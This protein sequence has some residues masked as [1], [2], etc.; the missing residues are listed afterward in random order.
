MIIGARAHDYGRLP[1]KELFRRI[2][3]DGFKTIQLALKKAIDGISRQNDITDDLLKTVQGELLASGLSVGVLGVYVEPSLYEQALRQ[4]SVMEF[5]CGLKIAKALSAG[6]IGT[7]TTSLEKQPQVSRSV[8]LK[9]LYTSLEEILPQAECLGV[10]VGI[11]P[12]HYHTVNTPE[13]TRDVL[14]TMQSKRLK[15]IFDPVNLLSPEEV[16]TQHKLWDRAFECFGEDI[17]AVHIK[18]IALDQS[19]KL[20]SVDLQDSIVD[21][22]Y[23]FKYLRE[24]NKNLPVLREEVAPCNAL[25]DIEFIGK[26]IHEN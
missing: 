12:V 4:S 7:E 8:A 18:G 17:V 10:T 16:P 22:D 9:C 13:L 11:E 21:Y 20:V 6:C 1:S 15:V 26:L 25:D 19:G 3:S 24:L 23:I 2:S 5:L 14:K